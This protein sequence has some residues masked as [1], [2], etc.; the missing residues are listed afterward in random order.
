MIKRKKKESAEDEIVKV[1]ENETAIVKAGAVDPSDLMSDQ[2]NFF[3]NIFTANAISHSYQAQDKVTGI[4]PEL[5][6]AEEQEVQLESGSVRDP[7]TTK[8]T[9]TYDGLLEAGKDNRLSYFDVSVLNAVLSCVVRNQAEGR[10]PLAPFSII[11]IDRMMTGKE[12]SAGVSQA[13]VEAIL[14]SLRILRSSSIKLD[15]SDEISKM[16]FKL[17]GVEGRLDNAIIEGNLINA[18]I[19]KAKFNGQPATAVKLIG[20][21]ILMRYILPKH[22]LA[23]IDFALLQCSSISK[24][25]A[26]ICMTDILIRHTY[27]LFNLHRQYRGKYKNNGLL[28]ETIY[29]VCGVFESENKET[30]RSKTKRIR[31]DLTTLLDYWKSLD[32]IRSYEY[33]TKGR[34]IYKVVIEINPNS[35]YA[36]KAAF[37]ENLL[38]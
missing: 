28:M 18:E 12:G 8:V 36:P 35:T 13:R 9:I 38:E 19:L 30:Q 32:Y 11:Q 27:M 10:N 23:E 3:D 5:C 33:V 14:N 6:N 15:I 2:L 7:I 4:L 29:K 22:Q 37:L 25:E 16:K 34:T 1:S 17:N 24:T 21:P 31:S 26:N 20:I